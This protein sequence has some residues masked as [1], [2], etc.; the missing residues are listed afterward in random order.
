MLGWMN[1]TTVPPSQTDKEVIRIQRVCAR[2]KMQKGWD[3]VGR[4]QAG[5]TV[6]ECEL[7]LK[8]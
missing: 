2:I 8:G 3:P 5:S 4:G 6:E 1:K 7:S